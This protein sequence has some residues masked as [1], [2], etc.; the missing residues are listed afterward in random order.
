M[1]FA[2]P[3]VI[4]VGLGAAAAM[5]VCPVA[6]SAP[7]AGAGVARQDVVTLPSLTALRAMSKAPAPI[8]LRGVSLGAGPACDLVLEPFSVTTPA[9]RFVVG[10]ISGSD[11][12]LAFDPGNVLLL[13]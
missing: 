7:P 13:R 12:P 1:A 3:G 10:N 4:A 6:T 11:R 2:S 9:T 5:V 8:L